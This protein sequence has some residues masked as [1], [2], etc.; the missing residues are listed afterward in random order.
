MKG[1][2]LGRVT[3]LTITQQQY[4]KLKGFTV[5]QGG[6]QSLCQKVYDSVKTQDGKLVANVYDVDL[7]RI[8]RLVGR[9][10]DGSWQ[11]VFREILNANK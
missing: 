2:V 7:E 11:D 3:K 6:H 9:P 5:G 8:N 4:D 1:K 10:D